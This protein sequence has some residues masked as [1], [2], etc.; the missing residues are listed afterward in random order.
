MATWTGPHRAEGT[1]RTHKC[2]GPRCSG[3]A[4]VPWFML[5]CRADWYATPRPLRDAVW[6]TWR[7]GAGAGSAEHSA[8]LRLAIAAAGR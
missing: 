4:D 5:M 3:E 6:L 2:P 7:D 8:A 1:P